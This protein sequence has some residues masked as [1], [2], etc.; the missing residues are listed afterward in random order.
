MQAPSRNNTS[1]A[2]SCPCLV[3]KKSAGEISSCLGMIHTS[4]VAQ[5]I[6]LFQ[7]REPTTCFCRRCREFCRSPR[8]NA[9][10]TMRFSAACLNKGVINREIRNLS[11]REGARVLHGLHPRSLEG[12][13]IGSRD[14]FPIIRYLISDVI[15]RALVIILSRISSIGPVF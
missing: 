11:Q 10:Y 12:V 15:N 14:F 7:S 8:G 9:I 6:T 5:G 1:S 13:G 3:A 4:T 2:L